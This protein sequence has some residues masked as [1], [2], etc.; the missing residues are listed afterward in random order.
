VI[1]FPIPANVCAMA[2]KIF[3]LTAGYGEGHNTAAKNVRTAIESLG[4]AEA[5]V[6][7]LFDVCYG[8]MN[9]FATKAYLAAIN[10]TPGIWQKFYRVLDETTLVEGTLF[11]MS[12][13]RGVLA[14]MIEDQKP[15][16]IVSTYPVYS[17]LLESIFPRR[18][19][20]GF[21]HTTIVTDSITINSVWHR[22]RS[23][24]FIVPNEETAKVMLR[25]GVPE[26][27]VKNLGFPVTTR[28]AKPDGVRPPPSDEAARFSS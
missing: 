20:R 6:F 18:T 14:K 16:A 10:R 5:Q 23:D 3:V 2:R 9:K 15:D 27:K 22:A 17:F 8:R 24:Y 19:P 26:E 12:R 28:F 1:F 13:M 25:A 4:N 21:V 11:T 7:D